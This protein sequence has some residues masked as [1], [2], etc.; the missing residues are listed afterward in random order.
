[1]ICITVMMDDLEG[2]L[3]SRGASHGRMLNEGRRSAMSSKRQDTVQ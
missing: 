1:M 2:S 3:S